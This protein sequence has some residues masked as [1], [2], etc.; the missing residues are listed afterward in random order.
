VKTIKVW[1]VLISIIAGMGIAFQAQA[2][3]PTL[4][5]SA[6]KTSLAINEQV[7]VNII[8]D[9]KDLS[10][11][12]AELHISFP[13]NILQAQSITAGSFLPVTLTAGAVTTNGA[14][15]IL[16]SQPATPVTGIGT[17]ATITF[18]AL[19]AGSAQVAFDATTQV[20]AVGV[21]QNALGITT[22]LTFTVASTPTVPTISSFT[23]SPTSIN[24]GQTATLSWSV[25]GSTALSIDQGVGTVTGL[26]SRSVAPTSSTTYILTASNSAGSVTSSATLTVNQ[27]AVAPVI[28]S[29]IASPTSITSG[30]TSTL[31]W[32]VTGTSPTLSINQGIGTVTGTS[33]TVSPTATTTYTL[34]ASNSAGTVTKTAAVTVSAA[35]QMPKGNFDEVRSSDGVVRGWSYDPDNSSASNTVQIFFDGA[36]GVGTQISSDATSVSRSDVN[37]TYGV[38]GNHG[39]EFTVPTSYRNNVSHSVYIYGIDINDSTKSTLLTGSPKSFTLAPP[40]TAPAISSF[41]ASPTSITSGS[42]STLSWSV[43]GSSPI[44][45]INQGVGTV[46]G[47]S[48]SV[49]PTTTTTYTLTASNSAGT[50]TSTVTVTVNAAII[51]PAISSFTASPASIT[52]GSSSTL[53]WSVSGSSPILSINQGVGTVTGTSRSVS[54]NSTTT[55]TL[56]ASNSAGTVT[57]TVTVTVNAAIIAP[58][59]SSFTASPASIT[60]GS[61]S[62]LSWSVSGSSPTLSI[63]QG[64]GT[65][66]GTSKSVSPTATTTY[67]L[68]ASNSVGTVTKSATVTV[69]AVPPTVTCGDPN[70]NSFLGCYYDNNNFTNL[71]LTRTDASINFD[72][73][74]GSPATDIG[75]DTFS[76][77]WQGNFSF[78]AGDYEFTATADDGLRLYLDNNLVL[79]KWLDQ[80]T[81]TYK[82][83]VT[84]TAGTHLIKYSYYENSGLAVAKLSWTKTSVT[85]P[86]DAP[87]ISSFTASPASI[88]SGSSS[89]LGWTVAGTSPTL[90]IDQGIGTVT[91]TSR[92]VSPTATITYTLTASNSA[93]TVTRSATVTVSVPDT[94]SPTVSVSSPANGSSVSNTISITAT[95]S[96]NVSVAGV[97]FKLDGA[98]LGAEDTVSPYSYSWDTNTI[99]NG[100]HAITAIARDSAGNTATSPAISIVVNNVVNIA[101]PVI[102][103]FAANST[104]ITAGASVVLSWS[105]TSSSASAVSLSINQGVGTVTGTSRIVSPQTTTTYTLTATNA[106]GSVSRAVTIT[107][108]SPPAEPPTVN[109]P[110]SDPPSLPN[111]EPNSRTVTFNQYPS[112][113]IFKLAGN[114]TVYIKEGVVARPITDWTVLKNQVPSSRTIITVPE[115]LTFTSGDVMGL[116]SGTLV[117]SSTEPI[118]YL[119]INNQ[120]RPFSSEAEFRSLSYSY[121]NVYTIND[122]NLLASIP[123][124]TAEFSRPFGTVLKYASSPAIFFLNSLKEKRLYPSM[125]IFKFW[126]ESLS[127]VITV[128]E[129]EVYPDGPIAELPDG[130]LVKG[131]T[132]T[133]YLTFDQRLRPFT[134]SDTFLNL[135]YSF[136][137]I[138]KVPDSDLA[139]HEQGDAIQPNGSVQG[140]SY[141]SLDNVPVRG[142][143]ATIYLLKDGRL[144]PFSSVAAFKRYGFKLSKVTTLPLAELSNYPVSDIIN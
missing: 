16:G 98:N 126:N 64:V 54:P 36:V 7:A 22:P 38:T 138:V 107:V 63:D 73:G 52:S 55:Y 74:T 40:A 86:T 84:L 70:T 117:K 96:D 78:D 120:K 109:P 41:T 127:S 27:S 14:S 1:V 21:T 112:G 15:I 42:S 106:T 119:I 125:T 90:S 28:P 9:A 10:V 5:F 77:V 17:L 83:T 76:A 82:K 100:S 114:P 101:A 111:L 71:K 93:G 57:S 58:A 75:A 60:S 141:T 8:M 135:G 102:S 69:T 87:V 137:D 92:T 34:T 99:V 108:N 79:D 46:T 128:P 85:P 67:T 3:N 89:T 35:N 2:V 116:R 32:T 124:T 11:S 26:N 105:I 95:A 24:S 134:Q 51:A 103:F 12:A 48:R 23:V 62:T 136:E 33:K 110:A 113:T 140:I 37:S 4:T 142:L 56:T 39:F 25:T 132:N 81:T 115:T 80:S 44:L 65:V 43:S 118:I 61:S 18:K 104:T 68:T 130:M 45:S 29:F 72:W 129:T 88:T 121:S 30:S 122:P 59:I 139:L 144:Y 6:P 19:T 123:T 66:T 13:G 91:G 131:S 133:V 49:S 143:D 53:S 97:Q 94:A 50:V 20:A 31:S 47:T